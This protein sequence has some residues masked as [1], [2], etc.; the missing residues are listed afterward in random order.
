MTII[1]LQPTNVAH[2]VMWL[3]ISHFIEQM[4]LEHCFTS[5]DVFTC[6]YKIVVHCEVPTY[7]S[8]TT[9]N[10]CYR[11]PLPSH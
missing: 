1:V 2:L 5:Y 8:L 3:K 4:R 11:L 9:V 6:L 7:S 10:M